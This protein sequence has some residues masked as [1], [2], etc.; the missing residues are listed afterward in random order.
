MFSIILLA[1]AV[2]R[3]N[4]GTIRRPSYFLLGFAPSIRPEFYA[5]LFILF[6][7][8][9]LR[10]R[11]GFDFANVILAVIPVAGWL[12]FAKLYYGTIVSTTFIVKAAEPLFSTQI[13][14]LVSYAKLFLSGNLT[15]I[16]AILISAAFYLI[17][18]KG[19]FHK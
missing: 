15:E 4:A 19:P 16:A 7:Y 14:T 8:L 12:G 1:S 11:R 9:I 5:F 17:H 13:G 6:V 18:R 3:E 2:Y 10:Q